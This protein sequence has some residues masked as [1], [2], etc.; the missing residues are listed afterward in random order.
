MY[1]IGVVPCKKDLARYSCHLKIKHTQNHED[2]RY[3]TK[4]I[5]N[6]L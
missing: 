2:G 3:N 6:R 5:I 4:E 1:G